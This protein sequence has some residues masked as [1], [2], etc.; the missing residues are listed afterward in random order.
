MILK[1]CENVRYG[2]YLEYTFLQSSVEA[3]LSLEVDSV[4]V[5]VVTSPTDETRCLKATSLE[6]HST[7][8]GKVW[9]FATHL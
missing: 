8:C 5:H 6:R 3:V 2:T 7:V 4:Q 9:Q 1:K